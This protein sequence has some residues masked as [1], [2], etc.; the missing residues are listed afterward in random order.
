MRKYGLA[1]AVHDPKERWLQRFSPG[2]SALSELYAHKAA[3]CTA[4]TSARTVAALEAAGFHVHLSPNGQTGQ[5][6]RDAIRAALADPSVEW[7]QYAD[8][9]RLLH[10]QDTFPGELRETL[11]AEPRSEYVALG[12]TTRALHTHPRVQILAETLTNSA[13]SALLGLEA[14]VDL[15]AGSFLFSRRAAEVILRYSVEPTGATDLEWPALILRELGVMPEFRAVEG[16][17]FETADYYSDEI[18]AAGSLADWIRDTYDRP[19][20]WLERT[21]L[22]LDSIAALARVLDGPREMREP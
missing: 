10:W 15:V 8:L 19:A 16:L 6:R 5:T 3:A 20:V 2:L 13:F 12:R 17:E 18:Q 11:A 4:A 1:V 22:A 14:E 21:K 9:D 7:L